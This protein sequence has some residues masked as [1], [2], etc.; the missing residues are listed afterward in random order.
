MLTEKSGPYHSLR[1]VNACDRERRQ[2]HPYRLR[3]EREFT[4][5]ASADVPLC[6]PQQKETSRGNSRP[7]VTQASHSISVRR[8]RHDLT[9]SELHSPLHPSE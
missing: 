1:L 5:L 2:R 8:S 6:F 7:D 9:I 3:N 4:D